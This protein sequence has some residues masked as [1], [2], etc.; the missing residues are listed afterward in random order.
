MTRKC[1]PSCE[2]PDMD[3]AEDIAA[4]IKV[5]QLAKGRPGGSFWCRARNTWRCVSQGI[6]L[7]EGKLDVVAVADLCSVGPIEELQ[8]RVLEYLVPGECRG[9]PSL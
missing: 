1:S 9:V 8:F 7:V 2:N 3:Y 4:S 6:Y 5:L